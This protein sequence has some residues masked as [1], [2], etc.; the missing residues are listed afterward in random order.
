MRPRKEGIRMFNKFIVVTDLSAAADAVVKNLSE[1]K[2]YGADECLLLECLSLPQVGSAGL[3]YT[4]GILEKSL[5]DQR[6]MLEKQGFKVETR[7]LPGLAKSEVNRIAEEE[8]Y[9]LIVAGALTSSL[10]NE[11]IWGGIAYE[12][13]HHCTRPT[14]LVRLGEVRHEGVPVTEPVRAEYSRHVLFPTDFSATA[15][16]AFQ[17]VRKLSYERTKKITLMHV[18]DQTRID[19][20][21]LGQLEEFNE[22]DEARL[23]AMK[24]DLQADADIEVDTILKYGNPSKEILAAIRESDMQLV[25]MG[26]QGR[27]FVN[28]LFLGSVSHNVA[29]H[30]DASV[31]L[32]PA[33]R[34]ED[35]EA[36]I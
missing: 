24:E 23:A 18:Q 3:Y 12:I 34:M 27:G 16:L 8:D 10:M 14:L 15:N 1:L 25:V 33:K 11:A 22:I 36:G 32:I 7:I 29:R 9:S 31:L 4:Y 13:I 17:T 26:S 6:E 28:D 35:R 19:P 20:H 21:L 2:A 30:S 5:Q